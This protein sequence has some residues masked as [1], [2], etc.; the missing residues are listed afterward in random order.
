MTTIEVADISFWSPVT[1]I[2]FAVIGVSLFI[3]WNWFVRRSSRDVD[4]VGFSVFL[5]LVLLILGL[6]LST[7]VWATTNGAHA[8]ESIKQSLMELGYDNVLNSRVDFT[9][10]LD[11]K[12]VEGKLEELPGKPNTLQV[13][14]YEYVE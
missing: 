12:Y 5:T 3:V 13:K 10:S 4:A 11:G 1:L 2:I 8:K 6:G 14:R 9:A 7:G